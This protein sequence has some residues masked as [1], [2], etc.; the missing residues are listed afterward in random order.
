[1]FMS[2]NLFFVYSRWRFLD[3]STGTLHLMNEN[4]R[5]HSSMLSCFLQNVEIFDPMYN[6]TI[7]LGQR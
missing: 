6:Y 3:V 4:S 1:M 2:I 5:N 7:F